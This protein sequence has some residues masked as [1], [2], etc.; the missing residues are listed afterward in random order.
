M[1]LI[2][3]A[4]HLPFWWLY[5]CFKMTA[6]FGFYVLKYRRTVVH[7]NIKVTFPDLTDRER[8]KL[9]RKFYLQFME[10]FAEMTKSYS[11]K[12]N[13]WQSRCKLLNPEVLK[14]HLDNGQAVVLM[15]GHTANW[16]WPAHSISQQ[17]DYP[18]EFLYKPLKNNR[19]EDIMRHLR[20]RHG[21]IP[22]QKDEATQEILKRKDRPR[23][24]GI[25]GDQMPSWVPEKIWTNF[26]NRDTAFYVGAERISTSLNYPVYFCDT[27]RI[28]RGYYE[29]TFKEIAKP[30]Y[31]KKSDIIIKFVQLLESAIRRNPSDYLWS[32]K[33]WKY[34]R[35]QID[36]GKI[37]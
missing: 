33:R 11:F 5:F 23:I 7:E 32:H 13:D 37:K 28:R 20:T 36:P 21:G 18:M 26:L 10:V 22:I 17:I 6:Y 25:I 8:L 27:V 29:I 31:S 1:F 24:I 9:E 12:K 19:F 30:P 3:L 4:A 14:F 35:D 34:T 15:S 2:K 16:E